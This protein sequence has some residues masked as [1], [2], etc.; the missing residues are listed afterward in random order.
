M[1]LTLQAYDAGRENHGLVWLGSRRL[2]DLS[3]H[4]RMPSTLFRQGILK[5]ARP[6]RI[7]K[8][9]GAGKEAKRM[10]S[11]LG[12]LRIDQRQ[13]LAAQNEWRPSK[14]RCNLTQRGEG[15]E[16]RRRVMSGRAWREAQWVRSHLL[17]QNHEE[18][19]ELRERW[20]KQ[21][22][23]ARESLLGGVR[24]ERRAVEEGGDRGGEVGPM[25]AGH[26]DHRLVRSAQKLLS[27]GRA[28]GG[29][30]REHADGAD[31][32]RKGYR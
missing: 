14:V 28:R 12:R 32:P 8:A 30:G 23:L 13:Q 15:L 27:R 3:D 18:G 9:Q 1:Q 26:L 31:C 7:R 6:R 20:E 21:H 2:P 5:K 25:R 4:P 19:L 22:E 16:E 17:A 10:S 29:G 24:S 11:N